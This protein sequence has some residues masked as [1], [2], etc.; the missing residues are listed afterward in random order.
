M[1]RYGFPLVLFGLTMGIGTGIFKLLES[2]L[3]YDHLRWIFRIVLGGAFAVY[4]LKFVQKQDNLFRFTK[5]TKEQIGLILFL[6]SLFIVN[7]YFLANYA[8]KVEFMNNA[9]FSLV[10][11]GFLVNSFFEEFAY[12]GFIQG[13]VNQNTQD[14]TIPIS[15]G[16]VLAS[17]LM[18][19]SH[20][21]FFFVMDTV[22]AITG[23]ILVL[24]F[25]LTLGYIR[26]KGG[27]IW[28]LIGIHTWMNCI[29]IMMNLEHY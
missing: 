16:N 18:L 6:S 12:R 13:Y 3:N 26:D 7:N 8:T 27:S 21:G 4:T 5:I 19:L 2:D 1:K 14:I 20:F 29:H 25:S 15:Q 22:F 24:I 10:L 23:L 9:S 17:S 28:L 11:W